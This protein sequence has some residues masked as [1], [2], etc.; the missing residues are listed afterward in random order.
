MLAAKWG[1]QPL[2]RNKQTCKMFPNN[3]HGRGGR[4]KGGESSGVLFGFK[5]GPSC[6]TPIRVHFDQESQSGS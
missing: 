5:I 1:F 6:F 2:N 4:Y 3:N